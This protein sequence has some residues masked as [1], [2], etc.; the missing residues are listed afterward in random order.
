VKKKIK[1]SNFGGREM[2]LHEYQ[3]LKEKTEKEA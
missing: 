2:P 3:R 1:D